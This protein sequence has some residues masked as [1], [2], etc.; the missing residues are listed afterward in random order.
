VRGAGDGGSVVSMAGGRTGTPAWPF[1]LLLAVLLALLLP[2]KPVSLS[3][4]VLE[5]TLDTVAIASHGTPDITLDDIARGKRLLPHLATGYELLENDMRAGKPKVFPA[6]IRGANGKVYP[7]HFFGYPAMAALPFALLERAG[8]PPFKA[9]Q[10]VNLAAVLVLGLALRR[11]FGSSVKA[12]AG[13]GLFMLCGGWLYWTWSS[14]ECVGA[15]ALL[16]GL[17]LFCSGAPISGA[18]LAG[19]AAQQ[20]P[21][22]VFFFGFA[23]ALLLAREHGPGQPLMAVLT[24]RHLVG[25]ALGLAV[26]AMPP[27]FNLVQFGALNPIARLFS[28]P[29]LISM[30]RLHSFF[31]DLNQGMILGIPAVAALLAVWGWRGRRD[32]MVL[33]LCVLFTLALALPALAVLNWNSG[34]AGIMRYAFW[35]SMT[36]VF[37]LLLRLREHAR[38]PVLPLAAAVL[39]QGAAMA[40]DESYDYVEFSPL[41]RLMLEHAPNRYHPEPEIFAE[42]AG[43]N[44]DYITP[45]KVYTL[46]VGDQVLKTLFNAGDPQHQVLLCGTAMHLA[47]DN[48]YTDSARGWRYIDGPARCTP[49]T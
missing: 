29:G 5:Y 43:R 36:F 25:L 45:G 7:I 8:L 12:L 10:V 40:H 35:A 20:N 46:R 48:I 16:S 13:V 27:L 21:T 3:G 28:D 2:L 41:A 31:F 49:G 38:W 9:F 47:Q 23:P 22:I 33:L 30:V 18:I 14:P 19:L 1:A 32:A 15:A 44:D 17:L 34:A 4:D 24:P 6:F 42:R 26:A 37:A 11:F 39:V